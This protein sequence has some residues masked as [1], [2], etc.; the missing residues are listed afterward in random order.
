ML[1][2]MYS[3]LNVIC[4]TYIY[5]CSGFVTHYIYVVAFH[6]VYSYIKQQDNLLLLTF[7]QTLRSFAKAQDDIVGS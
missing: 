2:L 7:L 3:S 1:V 5:C 4:H 6:R